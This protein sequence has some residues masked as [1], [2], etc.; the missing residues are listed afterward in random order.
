MPKFEKQP[1]NELKQ[2]LNY[3][4]SEKNTDIILDSIV[5]NDTDILWNYVVGYKLIAHN[6]ERLTI[7]DP[8]LAFLVGKFLGNYAAVEKLH[9]RFEDKKSFNSNLDLIIANSDDAIDLL[10][11]LYMT[12]A[13]SYSSIS[14]KY[15]HNTD[16]ELRILT[17]EKIV[18]KL[19]KEKENYYMLTDEARRYMKEHYFFNIGEEERKEEKEL[20]NLRSKTLYLLREENKKEE[21]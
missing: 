13:I 19:E 16:D 14:S 2:Y 6:L 11:D 12:P 20:D 5:N 10:S 17:K 1:S 3:I 21:L 4:L 15:Q 7:D 9:K 18:E 8:E